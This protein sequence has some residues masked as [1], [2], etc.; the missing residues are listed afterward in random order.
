MKIMQELKESPIFYLVL[1]CMIA[2]IATLSIINPSW[3]IDFWKSIG[4]FIKG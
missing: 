4:D 3:Q 1:V 2:G